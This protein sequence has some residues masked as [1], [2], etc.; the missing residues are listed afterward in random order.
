MFLLSF[1]LNFQLTLILLLGRWVI[2][3][4]FPQMKEQKNF[5]G[6][7]ESFASLDTLIKKKKKGWGGGEECNSPTN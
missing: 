2:G 1:F 6:L 4:V 5:S 3:N 7:S